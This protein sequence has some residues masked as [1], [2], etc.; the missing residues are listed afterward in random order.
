MLEFATKVKGAMYLADVY[1]AKRNKHAQQKAELTRPVPEPWIENDPTERPFNEGAGYSGPAAAPSSDAASA[2]TMS[3]LILLTLTWSFL[4]QIATW[5][6]AFATE[7]E[8]REVSRENRKKPIL[9][10]IRPGE[11]KAG[12]RRRFRGSARNKWRSITSGSVM[13]YMG[14]RMAA[15]AMGLRRAEHMW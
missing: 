14:I 4:A 11:S 12:A 8:V 3:A 6:T 5:S 7:E 2:N 9:T 1:K 13:V 15:A 10:R